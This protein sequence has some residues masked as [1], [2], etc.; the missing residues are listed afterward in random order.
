MLS[1]AKESVHVLLWVSLSL[2]YTVRTVTPT[3]G[4]LCEFAGHPY[5]VADRMIPVDRS[6]MLDQKSVYPQ[7]IKYN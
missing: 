3:L 5:I 2:Y 4:Q 1:P 6:K 7:N